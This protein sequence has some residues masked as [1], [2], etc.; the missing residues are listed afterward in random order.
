M[1]FNGAVWEPQAAR[2]MIRPLLSFDYD[3]VQATNNE[4]Y[5]DRMIDL[6]HAAI[7]IITGSVRDSYM[8][9]TQGAAPTMPKWL[10]DEKHQKMKPCASLE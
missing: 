1:H 4:T 5:R 6:F 7:S 8:L 3:P 9:L 10:N 2:T